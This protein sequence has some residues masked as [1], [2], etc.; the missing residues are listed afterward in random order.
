MTHTPALSDIPKEAEDL[1][2]ISLLPQETPNI[3]IED[4]KSPFL[5][6][7]ETKPCLDPVSLHLKTLP[8]PYCSNH[9]LI[10]TIQPPLDTQNPFMKHVSCD[11]VLV[12]DISASMD[13][14]ADMTGGSEDYGFT[15]L[16][17]VQHAA[18]TIIETMNEGDRLGIVTYS[19][20]ATVLQPLTVMSDENREVSKQIILNMQ[21]GMMTNMWDGIMKGL[22]LFKGEGNKGSIPALMVS[23]FLFPCVMNG[24]L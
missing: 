6:Q 19:D 23:V 14:A 15:I 18:L 3:A 20:N 24:Y 17:L 2:L 10:V 11:L 9:G 7:L 22:D 13:T 8:K 1:D 5:A 12:I 16:N 4:A 21:Y